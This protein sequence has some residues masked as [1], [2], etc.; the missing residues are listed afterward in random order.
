MSNEIYV[1]FKEESKFTVK[2]KDSNF[3][4][5]SHPSPHLQGVGQTFA[6]SL[7]LFERKKV[8]ILDIFFE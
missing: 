5:Q 7:F 6:E 1:F 3:K 8:F 4:F 2:N